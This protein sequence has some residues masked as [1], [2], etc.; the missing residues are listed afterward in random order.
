MHSIRREKERLPARIEA[1]TKHVREKISREAA[2][3]LQ[4]MREEIMQSTDA[5]IKSIQEDGKDQMADFEARFAKGRDELK[6]ELFLRLR[7]W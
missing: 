1:E 6:S 2:V 4:R 5:R 7:Q 3:S